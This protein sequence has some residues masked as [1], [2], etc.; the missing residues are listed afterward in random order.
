MK[1]LSIVLVLIG[2]LCIAHSFTISEKTATQNMVTLQPSMEKVEDEI[3][4]LDFQFGDKNKPSIR[5]NTMFTESTPWLHGRGLGD[6]KTYLSNAV[7][8]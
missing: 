5:Y 1:V 8:S 2:I 4:M 6:G 3:H 7:R